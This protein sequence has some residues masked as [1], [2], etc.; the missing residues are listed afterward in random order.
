MAKFGTTIDCEHPDCLKVFRVTH[1]LQK[2]CVQ[3]RTTEARNRKRDNPDAENIVGIN[4]PCANPT[5]RKYVKGKRAK[6]TRVKYCSNVCAT[7]MRGKKANVTRDNK[8][9]IEI[10]DRAGSEF[11]AN[12]RRGEIYKRLSATGDAE[13]IESGRVSATAVAE[14]YDTTP[15]SISRAMDAWRYEQEIR[16]AS[17]EFEWSW[18]VK[19]LFPKEKM[20]RLREIG[21]ADPDNIDTNEEFQLLADQLTAAYVSFSKY[22]FRFKKKRPILKKFHIKWIRA[23]I[24]AYGHGGKLYILSP[25][26]HG[27]SEC[28][29]RLFIWLIVMDPE[30]RIGWL[31]SSKDIAKVMLGKVKAYLEY[32]EDLIADTLPKGEAYKPSWGSSKSWATYQMTVAQAP[33]YDQKSATMTAF[34]RTSKILSLDF[35]LLAVDDIEDFDTTRDAD[36]R[37]YSKDKFLEFGT[38]KEEET[39]WFGIG[40]RQ[41]EDDIPGPLLD[42]AETASG[43]SWKIIVNTAHDEEGCTLDPDVVAGHDEAGCVLFPEV[44]SY[45]WLMEKK[46]EEEQL[47]NGESGRY[48]M[49]YLNAPRPTRG[50]VYNLNLIKEKALDR[51]RGLGLEGLPLGRLIAGIDPASR[52]TQAA[53]LWHYHDRVITLVDIETQEAGGF[54][55]ALR[56]MDEWF[57]EYGLTDW[58]YEDNSQQVEFFRDPRLL[59]LKIK[60]GLTVKNHTTGMNKQDPELGISAMA[61][62]YHNG[63]IR[64]PY[65]DADSRKAVN[66]LLKQLKMWTTDGV[67]RKKGKTDVKM[68]MWFPFPRLLRW[69][70]GRET[71][72][73]IAPHKDSSYPTAYKGNSPAWKTHYPGR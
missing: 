62:L 8:R 39:A 63:M 53:V 68:A 44:R 22:Y 42:A 58:I 61:P 72:E 19:A 54:A 66:V 31:A 10:Q 71:Q 20:E 3:H 7:N 47:L 56:I 13:A 59:E 67:A 51:S 73:R 2:Y 32:N 17:D 48:E 34:G 1:H 60:H 4:R 65:G 38:R 9:D 41:H 5:C 46:E 30:I 25:P 28:L 69:M 27:K 49:R 45:R 16:A 40:S 36:Q 14:L 12:T 11:G 21:L 57:E 33:A 70:G 26:R 50:L 29:I 24:V 23:I 35:D 37:L 18:R 64:L 55:G 43:Q 15:A 52:G 6:D